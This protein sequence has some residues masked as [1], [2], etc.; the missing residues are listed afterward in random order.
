MSSDCLTGTYSHGLAKLPGRGFLATEW[1]VVQ[2]NFYEQTKSR[3]STLCWLAGLIKQLW[4]A[5]HAA[6]WISRNGAQHPHS[7]IDA[8]SLWNR[9]WARQSRDTFGTGFTTWNVT[10]W[11]LYRELEFQI[12]WHGIPL[13]QNINGS[14][15][16]CCM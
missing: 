13:Q 10:A 16:S 8:L 6:M 3:H 5:S 12:S 2:A 9:K 4:K 7:A 15:I 11:H 1:E 14:P